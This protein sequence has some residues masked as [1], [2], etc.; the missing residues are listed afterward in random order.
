M[1]SDEVSTILTYVLAGA[2]SI[3]FMLTIIYIVLIIKSRDQK[4][5]KNKNKENHIKTEVT[6][7][8]K[9]EK[10]STSVYN[11]QSIYSFLEFDRIED[12]MIVRKNGKKYL[13]VIECQGI[14]YDLMSGL[15][16]NSVEQGFIQFL[17]TIRYPIQIY[18]QT[19]T[20]NLESGLIKYK[21]RLNLIR[22][23]LDKKKLQL[24]KKEGLSYPEKEIEKAKLEVTR[25][26]NLYEYGQD[27][28]NSTEAMNLNRNIL[29]KNYYIIIDYSP[30]SENL[31][32]LGKEEI[33]NM[34]F[35]ELY[36]KAQ[37]IINALQV[38]GV[39][40]KVMDSMEL[41]ELLYIAYNRDDAEIYDLGKAMR[42]GYNEMFLT[43]PNVLEK[44]M[45]EINKKI[46]EDSIKL[47]NDSVLE[48][49]QDEEEAQKVKE[50]EEEMDAIIEQMAKMI[51]RE[52][53]SLVGKN[54][55]DRAEEKITEKTRA[56]KANKGGK[57]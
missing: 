3:F 40:G 29:K 22:D 4:E 12:G 8:S 44:R 43:A 30:E 51:I 31:A 15:E 53:S 33:S 39:V 38:C 1:N 55:A 54:I 47:A 57:R 46:E 9:K 23:R 52:N 16:K 48:A 28:V 17:N 25:E 41:S 6:T 27:I 45:Y 11:K 42:A 24:Q 36:T 5:S 56:K 32:N 14:N 2:I 10:T 50:R 37:N 26:Q 18:V 20:I 7:K 35:A 13:M 19:R 34:A 49:M 21:Q